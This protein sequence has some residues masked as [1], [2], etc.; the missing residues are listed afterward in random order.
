LTAGGVQLL[1]QAVEEMGWKPTKP[2]FIPPQAVPVE[3]RD[4][5]YARRATNWCTKALDGKAEALAAM[6]P[7]TGRNHALNKAAWLLYRYALAGHLDI[8][9]VTTVLREAALDSGLSNGAIEATLGSAS[10]GAQREGPAEPPIGEKGPTSP[11]DPFDG[12]EVDEATGEVTAPEQ[13]AQRRLTVTRA[14][15][16]KVRPVHWF[17]QDRLPIGSLSLLAGREGIG[18][19]TVCYQLAADVTRGK[20]P[21]RYHGQ[22][23]PVIVAATEDSWEHTIVPRLMAAGAD[24]DLV[25]RVDVVTHDDYGS[26]LSLPRDLYAMEQLVT[27]QNAAMVLLD[28][29][30]S[31]LDARLD[32][33][34]DADVR[35][36]LEPLTALADRTGTAVVGLIHVNK[37][38]S[39]D[40]LN[41]IMASKAFTAVARA[42]LFVMRDPE[43]E[44]LRLLGQ[45]KNNL[46]K[47]ELPTLSF[48]IESAH[49]A[50]TD[51]G[52]VWTGRVRWHG[53]SERS[54]TEALESAG[55]GSDARTATQEASDWLADY[56][57]TQGG[58]ADSADVKKA[59]AAAGHSIDALKRARGRIKATTESY[60]FPRK[61]KWCQSEQPS[62][63]EKAL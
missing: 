61:T 12:L 24:L 34:K 40:P 7:D 53:E 36:A 22:I 14:S 62:S 27:E 19:S 63:S 16:I 9:L 17:W 26:T 42:V 1:H 54:I 25:L 32:T 6:Q 51:E 5:H 15:Q 60:G 23:R 46:G 50:D 38:Q 29:L 58:E 59:G 56:L 4:E 45:A 55:E 30:L 2:P 52:P 57:T 43:N 33:H 28:P 8:D 21:G 48:G 11:V 10:R 20:L 18:K 39:T 41:L 31:R 13:A 47:E 44:T 37:S 3:Q 35:R 49:V